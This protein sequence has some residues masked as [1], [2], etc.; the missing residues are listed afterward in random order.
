MTTAT[1]KNSVMLMKGNNNT[2]KIKD[3]EKLNNELTVMRREL[4]DVKEVLRGLI[5][6]IMSREEGL[7]DDEYN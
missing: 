1:C 7:D 5:Q 3:V 6:V 2:N 4:D